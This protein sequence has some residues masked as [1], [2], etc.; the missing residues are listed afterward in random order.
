M[1][2]IIIVNKTKQNIA[3]ILVMN[4]A[5]NTACHYKAFRH[6]QGFC[7]LKEV[8]HHS[9]PT[10]Y[11]SPLG[12]LNTEY[13]TNCFC[14]KWEFSVKKKK[15]GIFFQE[16]LQRLSEITKVAFEVRSS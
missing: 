9:Q 15:I 2:R 7:S 6:S 11:S 13:F 14:R 1:F 5:K 3:Y 16:C 4:P 10:G 12:L 8:N